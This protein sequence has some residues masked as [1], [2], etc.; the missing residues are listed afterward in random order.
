M[1]LPKL[2][3]RVVALICLLALTAAPVSAEAA[4]EKAV[5][6]SG[7]WRSFNDE[8][9]TRLIET[10]L[11]KSP[12]VS[13]FQ[14][15]L[16]EARA[17]RSRSLREFDPK[18]AAA[19]GLIREYSSSG[20]I[21]EV[22]SD[23]GNSGLAT[24]SGALS[25]LF[26]EIAPQLD[27]GLFGRREANKATAV[28]DFDVASLGYAEARRQLTL[29]VAQALFRA[30]TLQ[31]ERD[32]AV[33]LVSSLASELSGRQK[34]ANQGLLS[35]STVL[36]LSSELAVARAKA[37]SLDGHLQMAKQ[38][39][40]VIVGEA[41]SN[42]SE[43]DIGV[44]GMSPDPPQQIPAALLARRADVLIAE[45][46]LRAAVGRQRLAKLQLYPS[47]SLLGD[48]SLTSI[49]G[50]GG[51]SAGLWSIGLGLVLPILDRGR[52]LAEARASSA[53]AAAATAEFEKA[54]QVAYGDASNALRLAATD[55]T[56]MAS[57]IVAEE[58]DRQLYQSAL[59]G[60]SRGLIS[61]DIMHEAKRRWRSSSAELEIAKLDRVNHTMM[62]IYA[63]GDADVEDPQENPS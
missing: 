36:A 59:T 55:K 61:S 45:A 22:G 4:S 44:S 63:V 1:R 26:S 54:V 43:L 19:F 62:A 17:L 49:G 20:S 11:T 15:R 3:T 23:Q 60:L 35:R 2:H 8:A 5:A 30:R 42:P 25:I 34:L 18:G 40:L 10:A 29:L 13:I 32:Q 52:L 33:E 56:R 27:L 16:A 31:V 12:D 50:S 58:A 7:W 9:L 47:F 24:R 48:G 21:V 6:H 39:I 57:L 38:E 41:R 37:I 53:R 14:A 51:G 28:A 46:R